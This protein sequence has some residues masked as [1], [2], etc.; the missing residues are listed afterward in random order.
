MTDFAW[1]IIGPGRIARRFPDAV[2][3]LPGTPLRSLLGRDPAAAAQFEA[4]PCVCSGREESPRMSA[5]ALRFPSTTG[6]YLDLGGTIS[7]YAAI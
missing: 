5:G 6:A 4:T 3:R 1:A 7:D 2:F